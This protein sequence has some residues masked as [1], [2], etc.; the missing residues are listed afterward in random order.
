MKS[1]RLLPLLGALAVALT[2]PLSAGA[3]LKKEGSWPTAEKRVSFDFDGKP[4]EGL[5]E[6]AKEADWSLVVQDTTR[7]DGKH[8]HVDVT[9]QPADAVLEALFAGQDVIAARNGS[10]V[11]L[12]AASGPLPAAEPAASTTAVVPA[13][14]PSPTTRGEDR[15][16]FGGDL[17]IGKDE[18]VHT[19][20]L[21]GGSLRIEGTVTGDVIV[22]GGSGTIAGGAHVLGN[23]TTLG[24]SLTIQKDARVD[25]HA[26]VIGGVLNRE[27]G[28]IIG[29]ADDHSGKVDIKINEHGIA[30]DGSDAEPASSRFSRAAH[31]IGGSMTKMALLFVFGCVLLAL[32]APRM[33]RA[34]A[35]VAA[36]PMRSFAVGIVTSIF[37]GIASVVLIVALCIT[38]IGIPV[39]LGTV[40]FAVF[41]LYGAI[42]SVLTTVGAAF[43]GH[44]S[45][46]P[47][48]HLLAGC[49]IFLV[50]SLIPWIGGMV[51]FAI[52][53]MAIGVLVTTRAGGKLAFAH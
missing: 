52:T 13:S 30:T 9:D 24:G 49:A 45:K 35:E 50:A 20:T 29:S 4:S 2:L 44:R 53:M 36:R 33:E 42:A 41:A 27:E 14:I 16:V 8:V 19:V 7:V 12:R 6:L 1:P 3:A 46:N 31:E 21:A 26:G 22:A 28:A 38:I 47:Y 23:A 40:L 15:N 51:T 10:L 25:G 5:Q 32:L 48:V 34:Q 17:V 11:T 37:G 39:A 43:I 18:T